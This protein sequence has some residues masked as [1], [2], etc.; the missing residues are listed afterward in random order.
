MKHN[1]KSNSDNLPEFRCIYEVCFACIQVKGKVV[2]K[3][4]RH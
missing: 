3:N 2:I 1:P 4:H